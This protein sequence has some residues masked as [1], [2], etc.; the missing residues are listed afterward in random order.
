[1]LQPA[2]DVYYVSKLRLH[3]PHF[4]L[5]PVRL[6]CPTVRAVVRANRHGLSVT[7]TGQLL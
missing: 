7:Q 2:D 3:R 4:R 1:M 6:P 5:D